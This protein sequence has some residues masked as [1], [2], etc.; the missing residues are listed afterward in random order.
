MEEK[1]NRVFERKHTESMMGTTEQETSTA[2]STKMPERPKN[3][4]KIEVHATATHHHKQLD[5]V[6]AHAQAHDFSHSQSVSWIA[7]RTRTEQGRFANI[8]L[9]FRATLCGEWRWATTTRST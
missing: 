2:T 9:P 3:A 1:R 6:V 5:P 8:S 7:L 4:L